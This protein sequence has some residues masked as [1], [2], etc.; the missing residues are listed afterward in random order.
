MMVAAQAAAQR[1]VGFDHR[2][3]TEFAAPDHQCFV[4]QSAP[5]EIPT[6]AAEALSVSPQFFSWLPTRSEWAS[7]PSL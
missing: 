7:Q 2:R 5:F 6:S 4:E 3:A 1:R